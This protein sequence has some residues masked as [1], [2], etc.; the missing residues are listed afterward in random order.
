MVPVAI[1]DSVDGDDHILVVVNV[2]V[3]QQAD[4]G[5][6][7]AVHVEEAVPVGR[8]RRHLRRRDEQEGR[9]PGNSSCQIL[10]IWSVGQQSLL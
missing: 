7:G 8:A 9:H 6:A 2:A 1:V 3:L 4:Q 5:G 10:I